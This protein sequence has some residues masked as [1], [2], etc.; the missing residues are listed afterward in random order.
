MNAA[1]MV[2][3]RTHSM[4]WISHFYHFG[5]TALILAGVLTLQAG[6]FEA[7]QTPV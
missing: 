2:L 7:G 3:H 4:D 6:V 5:N 1:S